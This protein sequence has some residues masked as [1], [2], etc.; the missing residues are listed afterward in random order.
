MLDWNEWLDVQNGADVRKS[1]T[2]EGATG[3]YRF[4]DT[5]HDLATYV[6]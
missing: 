4:I 1:E 2:Y 5:P 3:G 6:H